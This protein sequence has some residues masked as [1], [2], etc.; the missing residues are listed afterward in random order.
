MRLFKLSPIK[1]NYFR[2][3][4][5]KKITYQDFEKRTVYD[6]SR[7]LLMK[8]EQRKLINE[9][10]KIFAPLCLVELIKTQG[11]NIQFQIKTFNYTTL[12]DIKKFEGIV[13]S[14]LKDL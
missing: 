8:K 13:S 2:L 9:L 1:L 5:R 10:M 3:Y 14:F 6:L 12:S 11:R 4:V 7:I